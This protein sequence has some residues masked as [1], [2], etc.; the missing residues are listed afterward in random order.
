MMSGAAA[1]PVS[2]VSAP[3]AQPA[4]AV[5]AQPASAVSAQPAS[6]VSSQAR[7][8]S[9]AQP[10]MP[11]PAAAPARASAPADTV[12]AAAEPASVPPAP[13]QAPADTAAGT[14]APAA[15]EK[16]AGR[17]S[18]AK[19]GSPVLSVKSMAEKSKTESAAPEAVSVDGAK[20][21]DEE[22]MGRWKD[23]AAL[24]SEKQPRLAVGL[25]NAV[26][27]MEERD[28]AK[29][30]VFKVMNVAQRDWI[31]EKCLRD[32]E[33]NFRKLTGADIKIDVDVVPD[34]EE[35]SV[36]Q[37]PY[38]NIEKAKDLIGRHEEV[39][40]LVSDFGLDVK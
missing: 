9:Q 17:R 19:A 24:Y 12:P 39:K 14:D 31:R 36:R 25:S 38:L 11:Q 21:S 10:V 32:I 18:R 20:L 23:L 27:S 8:A 6:T 7:T 28:G 40:N 2:A 4:P 30:L 1:Q 16:P 3:A 34:D 15:E 37:T 29:I 13:A 22:M 33:G 5:S 35:N 26:L